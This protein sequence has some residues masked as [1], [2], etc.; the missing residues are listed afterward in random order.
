MCTSV[1]F[2]SAIISVLIAL[3]HSDDNHV[4]ATAP[5][6]SCMCMHFAQARPSN[7]L[8]STSYADVKGSKKV[9]ECEA[10]EG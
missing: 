4:S 8:H 3:S 9:V 7:V 6:M 10:R 2:K 5:C 1:C